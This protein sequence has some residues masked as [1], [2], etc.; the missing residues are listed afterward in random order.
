MWDTGPVWLN[1]CSVQILFGAIVFCEEPLHLAC[2]TRHEYQDYIWREI[3]YIKMNN[4]GLLDTKV[5]YSVAT[6]T[7]MQATGTPMQAN[8]PMAC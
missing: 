5:Y 1:G 4:P 2:F 6:G 8:R 7:S 3:V